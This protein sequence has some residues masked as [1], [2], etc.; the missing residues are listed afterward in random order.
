LPDEIVLLGCGD[1][2]VSVESPEDYAEFVRPT[3]AAAD[4]RIG[5]CERVFTPQGSPQLNSAGALH[6]RQPPGMAALFADC[7]FDVVSVAANHTM[8]F[9]VE[10]LRDTLRT[11]ADLRIATVGAGENLAEARKPVIIERCGVT[12]AVL[13][14][15]SVLKDGFQA[16]DTRPG[17]APLRAHTYYEAVEFQAGTPPRVVTVPYADDLAAMRQD[18]KRARDRA[19]IV[20]IWPH[21][22]VHFIPRV[23]ADYQEAIA[24]AAFSAGADLIM[25]HH[26]HVPKAIADYGGK[27][28][29][30]SLGNFIMASPPTAASDLRK[31]YGIP[32]DPEWP[33]ALYG[34]DGKQSVMARA[35]LSRGGVRE[36]AFHP[37]LVDRLNRPTMPAPGSAQFADVVAYMDWASQGYPHEFQVGPDGAV[38]VRSSDDYN[39]ADRVQVMASPARR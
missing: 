10:G 25:G 5:Q 1:I 3:L 33:L 26:A 4:L 32:Y 35:R 9:G 20:V 23:I 29:F 11:F 14:Y 19:D 18:I 37:L 12:V 22:G 13:A 15:C 39:P 34:P 7:G 16:T 17:V 36:I 30:Y 21:W 2:G 8:N 24:E 38:V 27:A 6:L 31:L 28:C